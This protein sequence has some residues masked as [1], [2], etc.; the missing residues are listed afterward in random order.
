MVLQSPSYRSPAITMKSTCSSMARATSR[1]KA[2]RGCAQALGRRVGMGRQAD[3]RA[4]EVDVG[5]VDEF[6]GFGRCVE[7]ISGGDLI[8]VPARWRWRRGKLAAVVAG[9]DHGINARKFRN[10]GC[11][12]VSR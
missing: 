6:H 4:V 7:A 9:V 12:A 8:V 2:S 11:D 3:Q 10:R 1:S 5:G